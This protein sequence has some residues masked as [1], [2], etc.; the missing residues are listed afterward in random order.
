MP[1]RSRGIN[2]AM[3]ARIAFDTIPDGNEQEGAPSSTASTNRPQKLG[4]TRPM[5]NGPMGAPLSITVA[6]QVMDGKAGT[7]DGCQPSSEEKD[8]QLSQRPPAAQPAK[9]ISRLANFP[10]VEIQASR[11]W[12]ILHAFRAPCAFPMR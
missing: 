12:P 7:S 5:A 11:P 8:R 4:R 3:S 1:A 10:S 9:A 6:G 2:N